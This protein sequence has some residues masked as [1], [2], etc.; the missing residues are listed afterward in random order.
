ML[1]CIPMS[2][3]WFLSNFLWW[4]RPLNS[5]SWYQF[6]WSRSHL[7]LKRIT[8]RLI[9]L[10]ICQSVWMKFSICRFVEAHANSI[11]HEYGQRKL[12]VLSGFCW[13]GD[14]DMPSIRCC[15]WPGSYGLLFLIAC[16][17]LFRWPDNS[18]LSVFSNNIVKWE[19]NKVLKWLKCTSQKSFSCTVTV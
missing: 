14:S 3:R 6:G 15:W 8:W 17:M 19:W 7:H 11:L 16:S 4:K 9:F 10:Q 12:F 13:L 2:T 18:P 5:T 1:T